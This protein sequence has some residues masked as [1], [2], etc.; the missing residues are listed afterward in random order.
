MD[1]KKKQKLRYQYRKLQGLCVICGK[2]APEA[3]GVTCLICRGRST[4]R[5]KRK[6]SNPSAC[7]RCS[8][9]KEDL[10]RSMCNKC[11]EIK[12]AYNLS[13]RATVFGM[14]ISRVRYSSRTV[15]LGHCYNK[16]RTFTSKHLRWDHEDFCKAFPGFKESGKDL[17]HIIPL[18]CAE[19]SNGQLDKNF[20]DLATS[21]ENLQLLTRSENVTK[22]ANLDRQIISRAKELRQQGRSGADL[23]HQL[24]AEFAWPQRQEG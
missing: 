15:A 19:S 2:H 16:K 22:A 1:N 7:S 23:F 11:L 21:L 24:W 17:D 8:K 3:F 20:G 6:R 9:T 13:S 18:A 5:N 4:T 12:K 10:E 14:W